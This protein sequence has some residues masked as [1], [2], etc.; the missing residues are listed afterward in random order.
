MID[1]IEQRNQWQPTPQNTTLL[2]R[3]KFP[4]NSGNRKFNIVPT[5]SRH[6]KIS[7]HV[8]SLSSDLTLFC[9]LF[10]DP[11]SGVF[12]SHVQLQFCMHL[13]LPKVL[14]TTYPT[15]PNHQQVLVKCK[16]R[17]FSFSHFVHLSLSWRPVWNLMA[18]Q[19]CMLTFIC[20]YI[21]FNSVTSIQ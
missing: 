7:L 5:K 17:K 12:P 4:D 11:P 16:L 9:P 15:R 6:C 18:R 21:P 1:T 13:F 10:L 19:G 3:L 2:E 8:C 14:Y 20:V